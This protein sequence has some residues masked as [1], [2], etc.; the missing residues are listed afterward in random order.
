M[1]GKM[2]F[3]PELPQGWARLNL[4]LVRRQRTE[5]F[6]PARATTETFE[7]YSV[8]SHE[9][10]KPEFVVG[11]AIGSNKQHVLPGDVLISKIN[12]RLNR[13]WVVGSFSVHR[14]IA[15]TEWIVFPATD[16]VDAKYLRFALTD[17]RLRDYLAQHASGVGGSLTR[18]RPALFDAIEIPLP[19][20]KE[21]RRIVAKIEELLSEL[22]K[23]VEALTTV[24]EQV[25]AYR[26]AVLKAA[27]AGELACAEIGSWAEYTVGQLVTDVRYGTAKKCAVDPTKTPVLR[28]PNIA[29]GRIDLS[30]LKHTDFDEDEM[31]KLRLQAGDILIV[32]SNGSASLVGLSAVVTDDAAGYAYAGYLIRLRLN[33]DIILP[34]FLNLYLH[35]PW[36]RAGIERQARSSSGVHNVNSDE[37]RAIALRV[38]SLQEQE[39]IVSVVGGLLSRIEDIQACAETEVK[40]GN[41]LRQAIL[42]RA[43][44]GYLVAQD[45][46]DEPA[47]ALLE[48]IRAGREDEAPRRGRKPK[49]DKKEV[50]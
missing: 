28:I 25:A 50:A 20:A 42:Q 47:A 49:N 10:G 30:D 24:R 40:R 13:A 29:S 16:H 2:T 21:Q 33:R 41:A 45:P 31:E 39:R 3:N 17:A 15:S 19:P 7:L 32:R 46:R 18:A 23:G 37:I 48:R 43:F 22:D 12:P 11:S 36:V 14:K 35:S 4:A 5:T 1:T 44:S 8:P 9:T 34:Q 27:F 38:P 6:N 26:Q